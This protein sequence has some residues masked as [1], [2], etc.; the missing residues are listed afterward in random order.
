M[1]RTGEDVVPLHDGHAHG[2]GVQADKKGAWSLLDMRYSHLD[3]GLL[4]APVRRPAAVAQ[5]PIRCHLRHRGVPLLGVAWGFSIIGRH[6]DGT[7][8]PSARRTELSALCRALPL[9]VLVLCPHRL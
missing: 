9:D 7:R 4:A 3:G 1:D 8:E 6:R 2:A 5:W